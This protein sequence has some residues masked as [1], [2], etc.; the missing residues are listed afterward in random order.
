MLRKFGMWAAVGGMMLMV[1][2]VGWS[3]SNGTN[4]GTTNGTSSAPIIPK[5]DAPAPAIVMPSTD[6]G[7]GGS[8]HSPTSSAGTGSVKM[9]ALDEDPSSLASAI[10]TQARQRNMERQKQLVDDTAKLVSL[11]NELKDEVDKSTKDE[12]SLEVVRKADEIEKLAHNVKERMK[13]SG[14]SGGPVVTP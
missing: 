9:R 2:G 12:L 6:A 3:Q 4:N 11:V 1:G 8:T 10:A 5:N 13:C 7:M 14:C